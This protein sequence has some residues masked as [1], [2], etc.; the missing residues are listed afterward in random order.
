MALILAGSAFSAAWAP[1]GASRAVDSSKAVK[2]RMA[3]LVG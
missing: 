3:D 1:S 2:R